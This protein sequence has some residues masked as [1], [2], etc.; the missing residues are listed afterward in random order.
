[1]IDAAMLSVGLLGIG[2]FQSATPNLHDLRQAHPNDISKK[3][4]ILDASI[5]AVAVTIVISAI[6]IVRDKGNPTTALL[7]IAL[8][9]FY[10]YWYYS[11]SNSPRQQTIEG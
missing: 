5:P 9:G 7:L 10:I 8:T 1:M 4:A 3:Q 6:T 2:L 11:V